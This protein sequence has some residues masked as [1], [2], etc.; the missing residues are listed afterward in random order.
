VAGRDG[1][2]LAAVYDV[3]TGQSWRL[4]SSEAQPEASVVKLDILE[5]LLAR[6]QGAALSPADEAL[7]R[8]MIEDS[9]NDAATALWEAVGGA[10]GIRAYNQAVGLTSTTPSSCVQC[11]GFPWPGWG[12]TTTTPA[13][14]ISLLMQLVRPGTSVGTADRDYALRLMENV[15]PAQRWGVS[16]GVPAQVTVALKNGWLPLNATGTDWQ[17]N[18]IGWVSGQGRDYLI[19]VMSTGNPA[20]AYGIDTIDGLSAIVWNGL[21]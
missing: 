7:A 21:G 6:P 11:P 16:G 13:D 10:S 5:T 4:G 20:E 2:V 12:L 19:A 15:A 17:I 1:T 9:D 3:R 14:Q 18:S 8:S